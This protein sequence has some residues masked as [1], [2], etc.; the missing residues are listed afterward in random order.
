[1]PKTSGKSGLLAIG[2]LATVLSACGGTKT[3]SSDITIEIDPDQPIVLT[4]DTETHKAPWFDFRVKITN[5]SDA[6]LKIV[7]VSAELEL[8][9]G[10]GVQRAERAWSADEE[11]ARQSDETRVCTYVDFGTFAPGDSDYLSAANTSGVAACPEVSPI[12][13]FDKAPESPSM[14]SYR[15]RVKA[16]PHGW[17]INSDGTLDRFTRFKFFSTR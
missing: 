9:D 2:L 7:A 16:I 13:N 8:S 6:S 4:A 17:F 10:T 5:G 1:M 12:F 15:Y 3:K 11:D 14:T